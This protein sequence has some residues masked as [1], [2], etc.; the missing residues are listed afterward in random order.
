MVKQLVGEL[1]A[2]GLQQKHLKMNGW[3]MS[4]PLGFGLFSGAFA[5][6]L[7]VSG[8]VDGCFFS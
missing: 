3:K 2:I 4:F 1:G 8:P 7:L 5:V 6:S